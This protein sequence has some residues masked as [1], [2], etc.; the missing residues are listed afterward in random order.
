MNHTIIYRIADFMQKQNLANRSHFYRY[1]SWLDK[2]C[3]EIKALHFI[4]EG[5]ELEVVRTLSLCAPLAA[6]DF[7]NKQLP[8]AWRQSMARFPADRNF[9]KMIIAQWNLWASFKSQTLEAFLKSKS[10]K[11]WYEQRSF[12]KDRRPLFEL[13]R[14]YRRTKASS[15]Q[16]EQDVKAFIRKN[17]LLTFKDLRRLEIKNAQPIYERFPQRELHRELYLKK[18]ASD[19]ARS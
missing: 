17:P 13:D 14:P 8:E 1:R 18:I 6:S 4:R 15:L 9:Y 2:K 11:N 19:F 3:S 12:L 5:S 16:H 7:K 10:G